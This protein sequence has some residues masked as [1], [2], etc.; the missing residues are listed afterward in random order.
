MFGKD[1]FGNSRLLPTVCL[2]VFAVLSL[3]TIISSQTIWDAAPP[4]RGEVSS[5]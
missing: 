5:H 4:V 2:M 3:G 1:E